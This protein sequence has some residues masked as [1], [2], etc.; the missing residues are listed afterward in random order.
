EAG[1]YEGF[2]REIALDSNKAQALAFLSQIEGK[3][4]SNELKTGIKELIKLMKENAEANNRLLS[5]DDI[6]NKLTSFIGKESATSV[7]KARDIVQA[8]E[9]ITGIYNFLAED[10]GMDKKFSAYIA[11]DSNRA[12]IFSF[13]AELKGQP[14]SNEL[15]AAMKGLVDLMKENGDSSQAIFDRLVSFIPKSK[16]AT[17]VTKARDMAQGIQNILGMHNFLVADVGLDKKFAAYI[18]FDSKKAGIFLFLNEIQGKPYSKELASSMKELVDLMK[19]N[20]KTDEEIANKL[21]S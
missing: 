15:K 4:Y 3:P 13:L 20:G 10:V 21:A 5:T 2:A 14:Y 12:S 18:A 8:I 19:E 11:L 9:A 6:F 7:T 16:S 1:L 17:P